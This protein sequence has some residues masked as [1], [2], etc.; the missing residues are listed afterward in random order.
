[1]DDIITL[2]ELRDRLRGVRSKEEFI[3]ITKDIYED[4]EK[5]GIEKKNDIYLLFIYVL[6]DRIDNLERMI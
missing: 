5:Y 3:D 2:S 1:M 6:N 4:K